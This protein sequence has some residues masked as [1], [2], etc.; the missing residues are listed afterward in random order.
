MQHGDIRRGFTYLE[1]GPVVLVTSSSDGRDDIMTISW[2]MVM[3]FT[4]HIAISTGPWNESYQRILD[5][6]EC[7]ICVPGVDLIDAAV[8]IGTTSGSRVDKFRACGL[9]KLPA[10]RVRAPLIAECLACMECRLE[11]A[12]ERRGLLIFRGIGLWENPARRERRTF[13]ANGDGT[14]FTDGELLNRRRQML[15]WVPEGCIRF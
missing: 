1:P 11:E 7:V 12:V 2:H 4:P 13:H 3:D 6:R 14:F 9:T 15:K 8:T 10:E 5:T